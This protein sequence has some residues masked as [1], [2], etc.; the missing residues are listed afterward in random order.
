MA[1]PGRRRRRRAGAG[2]AAMALTVLNVAYPLAPVGPDAVGG[3]EQI[4]TALDQAVVAAGHTS[5]VLA[6]DGSEADGELVTY[7]APAPDQPI[8]EEVCTVQR[9]RVARAMRQI[10]HTRPV[11]VIHMHGLDFHFYLPP[12]GLPVLVTLH[13]P[14]HW[15]P[16]RVWECERSNTW[17]SCVSDNQFGHTWPN[18]RMLTP[19]PNGVAV[20]K[21]GAVRQRKCGYALMLSRVCPEKGLHL[22]LE[23]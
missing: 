8:T 13:L 6:M 10:L 12:P 11:D 21:L 2:P 20:E 4:L 23:A 15:Y 7:P 14:P 19:I 18:H 1:R 16:P 9:S 22:A 3:S 17:L 5:I